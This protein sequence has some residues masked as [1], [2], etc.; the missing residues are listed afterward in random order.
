MP[1]EI[2]LTI[3]GVGTAEQEE[4]LGEDER[5]AIQSGKLKV[6]GI[7]TVN[8]DELQLCFSDPRIDTPLARPTEFSAADS[9]ERTLFFFNRIQ[10]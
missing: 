3:N 10:P 5:A 2:D 6:Y 1:Y 8:G 4:E 9:S 7:C